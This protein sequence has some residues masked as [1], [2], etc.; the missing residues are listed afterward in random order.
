MNKVYYIVS[1]T[2]VFCI[3]GCGILFDDPFIRFWN[4]GIRPS[5]NEMD[6]YSQCIVES[7]EKYPEI[8]DP[9]GSKRVLYTRF[10]MKEKGY[11]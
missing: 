1:L 9:E 10:C 2:G 8:I 5:K 3:S 6:T 4:N 11:W 7:R